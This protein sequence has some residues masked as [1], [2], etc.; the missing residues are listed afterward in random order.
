MVFLAAT[1]ARHE[2]QLRS[3]LS[4]IWFAHPSQAR[5]AHL[6]ALCGCAE[7]RS[8]LVWEGRP[9]RVLLADPLPP[10]QTARLSPRPVWSSASS[11]AMCRSHWKGQMLVS[12]PVQCRLGLSHSMLSHRWCAL[13]AL[14]VPAAAGSSTVRLH[15][16]RV[17]PLWEPRDRLLR[18]RVCCLQK[19]FATQGAGHV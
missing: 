13:L 7:V 1:V 16:S 10:Q 12:G 19:S 11:A 14:C 17:V 18:L 4:S 8:L 3:Q 5:S 15:C 6:G 9:N 2:L